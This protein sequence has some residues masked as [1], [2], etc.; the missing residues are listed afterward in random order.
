MRFG[1]MPSSC[2]SARR[3]PSK[4]TLPGFFWLAS[5]WL[6]GWFGLA[7]GWFWF[8]SWLAF[9]LVWLGSVWLLAGFLAGLAW[10]LAGF[11]LAPGWLSGWFGLAP[12]WFGLAPGWL[13][14]WCY[15]ASSAALPRNA[16]V[17][18][19]KLRCNESRPSNAFAISSG[20]SNPPW[21]AG[22]PLVSPCRQGRRPGL[23]W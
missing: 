14:G 17:P 5:G 19:S 3:A 2:V 23:P 16:G 9:W 7:P 6:S 13:S 8:G 15:E 18:A 20:V 12:G 10:L 21:R 11:G 4:E 1:K 22:R